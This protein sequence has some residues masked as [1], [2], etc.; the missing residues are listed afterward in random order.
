MNF[1]DI[2]VLYYGEITIPKGVATPGLD[3]DLMIVSPYLGF[4]LQNGKHNVL[5]D[6]GISDD[7]IV[8]GKAWGN[9]PAK[10]GRSYVEQSLAQAGVDPLEIETILFTHLHNDHAANIS[11]F[12]NARLIFQ[13]D[14][15]ATLLDPLPIMKVRK[16]YDPALVEELKS[17]NCIKVHGDFELT[18]GIKCVLTPGHTPGSMSVAVNTANGIRII[19]GDLWH[20][21]CMAFSQQDEIIDMEGNRHKITPAPHV[22]GHFIP[23]AN[24]IYDYFAYYDS[25]YKLLSMIPS[26]SP[27]YIMPGHE[28]ALLAPGLMH[29]GGKP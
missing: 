9:F 6:T 15:W 14:E 7:F 4:L 3:P 22:L 12:K 8:D 5:V 26:D 1:W 25:C 10:G 29:S 2:K 13:R 11:I 17:G 28:P 16:D 27:E 18:E 19:V 24:L 21:H 20:M 23:P